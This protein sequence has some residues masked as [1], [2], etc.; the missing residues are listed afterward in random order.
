MQLTK[1]DLQAI[2]E[3]MREEVQGVV[4]EE[5]ADQVKPLRESLVELETLPHQIQLLA[6]TQLFTNEKLDK[7]QTT[8]DDMASTVTA[9]DVLHQMRPHKA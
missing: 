8:V 3:I 1:E 6:E 5:V 4:R 2:R 9:L 7:L